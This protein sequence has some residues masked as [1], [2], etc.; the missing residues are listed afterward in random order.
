MY[1]KK[2]LNQFH[3]TLWTFFQL[4]SFFVT[5]S[6]LNTTNIGDF[7]MSL[8]L[9]CLYGY[10]TLLSAS[11]ADEFVLYET[12]FGAQAHRLTWQVLKD[13]K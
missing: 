1:F 4:W 8:H 2:S 9:F 5:A 12:I 6:S 7:F 10:F 3:Y 11:S 13:K